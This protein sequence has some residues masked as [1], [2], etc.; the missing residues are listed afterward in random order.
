MQTGLGLF[1][2]SVERGEGF[3][4]DL[5]HIYRADC[6]ATLPTFPSASVDL[7]ITSP[8][9]AYNRKETYGGIRVEHYVEWFRPISEQLRRVLKPTGSF[10]L[11]IK[12]RVMNGERHPYVLELILA[13]RKQGWQWTEEYI[14]CKSNCYPGKWPN[15]FRDSWERC[16]HF[17]KNKHFKM[18]QERVMVDVG[19]WAEKRLKKLSK[20]DK[21]R[22]ESKTKSGFGKNV[23]EWL[24]REKVYPTNVIHMATECS[25]RNHSA[26]FPI[27]LP[28]WF[29]KLFTDKG[30]VV[31]D[32]FMG[33]GT[34]A[35]SCIDLDRHYVGIE[36]SERY[37]QE[38]L[39]AIERRKK[40]LPIAIRPR[41][42]ATD[43]RERLREISLE[44]L[45]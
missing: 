11:N 18:R 41:A 44:M 16:L 31:L 42:E 10:V 1:G 39:A 38:A 27:G 5:D 37:Y 9:Y 3:M 45:S 4:M 28:S 26:A 8:P 33:A 2:W 35:I 25:N 30:D 15:R 6:A 19:D 23:S 24:G 14:W 21:I 12:E 36:I 13:M 29:I 7:V 22:D 43:A 17:T 34:T 32:P 40:G 20:T